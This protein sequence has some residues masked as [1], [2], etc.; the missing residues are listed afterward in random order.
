MTIIRIFNFCSAIVIFFV[1]HVIYIVCQISLFQLVNICFYHN[2][3]NNN[4]LFNEL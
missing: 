1:G 3:V 2:F 4:I